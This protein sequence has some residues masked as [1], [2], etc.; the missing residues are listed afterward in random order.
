MLAPR[1]KDNENSRKGAKTQTNS[2]HQH[3]C[4]DSRFLTLALFISFAALRDEYFVSF[5]LWV[6][7]KVGLG[8][9]VW[10]I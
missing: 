1:N 8:S 2:I 7:P 10:L 9:F 4:R 5:N 6:R 3:S